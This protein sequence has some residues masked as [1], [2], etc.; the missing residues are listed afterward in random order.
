[1]M[2]YATCPYLTSGYSCNISG[3][4]QDGYHRDTYCMS[5]DKWLQCANYK[6]ASQQTKSSKMVNK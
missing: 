3:S 2:A 6:G 4:Y 5:K 1:M